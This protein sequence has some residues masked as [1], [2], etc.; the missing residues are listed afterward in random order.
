MCS[1]CSC[2]RHLHRRYRNQLSCSSKIVVPSPARCCRHY[3]CDGRYFAVDVVDAFGSV[4]EQYAV[5]C[6]VGGF[7]SVAER[8][9]VACTVGVIDF[10]ANFRLLQRFDC[11]WSPVGFRSEH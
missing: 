3:C 10:A 6:T 9:A 2:H 5:A 7:G 4:A 8:F 1:C 11:R